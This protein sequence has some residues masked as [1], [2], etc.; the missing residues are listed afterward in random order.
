MA[1]SLKYSTLVILIILFNFTISEK[2]DKQLKFDACYK[3]M[4]IKIKTDHAYFENLRKEDTRLFDN[5]FQY[6][7]LYCYQNINYYDAE[8]IDSKDLKDIDINSESVK[9][10]LSFEKYEKIFRNHN[11]AEFRQMSLELSEAI[12]DFQSGA[13]DLKKVQ[14]HGASGENVNYNQ[15][16]DGYTGVP[17]DDMMKDFVLFGINFSKLPNNAKN[18]IGIS[19]IIIIFL[20]VIGGLKWIQNI[21][22]GSIKGKKKKKQKAK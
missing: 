3:L 17:E 21:R 19:L 6:A 8:D 15:Q 10:Y 18:I 12:Q 7:L 16:N 2:S 1:F 5:A 11:E 22:Q 14:Q 20:S 4:L 9:E 13:I